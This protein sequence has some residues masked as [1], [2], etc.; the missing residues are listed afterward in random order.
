MKIYLVSIFEKY[1][2]QAFISQSEAVYALFEEYF[3]TFDRQDFEAKEFKDGMREMIE[4]LSEGSDIVGI[5]EF[6]QVEVIEVNT[7]GN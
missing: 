2:K 3:N 5:S 4:D 1:E 7:S 6:G